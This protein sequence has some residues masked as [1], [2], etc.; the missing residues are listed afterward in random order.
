MEALVGHYSGIKASYPE[1]CFTISLHYEGV[2]G[3]YSETV[4]L[5][6]K[7]TDEAQ[8]LTDYDVGKELHEIREALDRIRSKSEG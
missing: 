3:P 2:G 8:H 4:D 5:S 1:L 7:P 6:L